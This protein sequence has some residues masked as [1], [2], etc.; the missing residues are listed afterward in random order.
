MSDFVIELSIHFQ[1]PDEITP[2][3]TTISVYM[4]KKKYVGFTVHVCTR[5]QQNALFVRNLLLTPFGTS[6]CK[7]L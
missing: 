3:L 1:N 4:K 2:F 7:F 5:K 6:Y